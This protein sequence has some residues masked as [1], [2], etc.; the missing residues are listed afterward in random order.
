MNFTVINESFQCEHCGAE[1]PKLS[2]SCRNHCTR[3]L[4]SKHVDLKSPGD[5]ASLCQGLMRPIGLTHSGK[6]GWILLHECLLCRHTINN[7]VADDDDWDKVV[8]VGNQN[9][10]RT[11]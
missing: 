2:G 10:A 9:A 5:R 1:V 6:K 8:E 7:K 11:S 3:C 4:H